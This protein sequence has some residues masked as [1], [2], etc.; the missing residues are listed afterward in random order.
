VLRHPADHSLAC[1]GP[2]AWSRAAI[3]KS[4]SRRRSFQLQFEDTPGECLV[5]L[6]SRAAN[7]S[8]LHD[9]SRR[10]WSQGEALATTAPAA[11][12]R[13]VGAARAALP[14][15]S[16]PSAQAEW[17][18]AGV[19]LVTARW[20]PRR[21]GRAAASRRCSLS[22]GLIYVILDRDW[23]TRACRA[24]RACGDGG[25]LTRDKRCDTVPGR[26][27]RAGCGA[28]MEA[29]G[30]QR[31]HSRQQQQDTSWQD[32]AISN[33]KQI[34]QAGWACVTAAVDAAPGPSEA[35]HPSNPACPFFRAGPAPADACAHV[36]GR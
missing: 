6:L 13:R 35:P 21:G 10:Y 26:A 36:A 12:I 17:A 29:C 22:F 30:S 9:A 11:T 7:C 24:A 1:C 4:R 19:L 31:G 3:N 23:S 32:R 25:G 34:A 27:G 20:L 33:T 16:A 15:C 18:R 28:A 5:A 8:L 2:Q 14:T